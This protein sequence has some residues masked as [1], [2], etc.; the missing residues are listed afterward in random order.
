MEADGGSRGNPGPAGYGAVVLDGDTG[1]L[2]EEIAES[3]G[4]ATNNV[5]EYR[6]LLA[7]LRAAVG[8][9]PACTVEVRMDSK[10]VVEQMSGRWQI[11]HQDMR[12]LAAQ[13]RGVLPADRVTYT[14]IPRAQNTR[15]DALANQAMDA[16]AQ[17][18]SWS[19]R[20]KGAGSATTV[21]MATSSISTS[22]ST[23][24]TSTTSTSLATAATAAAGRTY[25]EAATGP[26]STRAPAGGGDLGAPT[27]LLL[28]RHGRTLLTQERRFSGRGGR[29]AELTSSGRADADRAAELI[30]GLGWPGA[31]LPEIGPATAV[32]SSPLLRTRQ[33]AEAVATRLGLTVTVMDD[34]AEISFGEWDGLTFAEVTERWPD[35]VRRWQGSMT[36]APPGGES[37][38]E[39]VSRVRAVRAATVAAFPGRV[40]VVAT[41]GVPVRAAVHEALDAGPP[42][43]WRTRV[44]PA[45]VTAVR[46]WSDGGIEVSAVNLTVPDRS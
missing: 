11:K 21:S 46:Y 12:A 6:G 37:L 15:A 34:W 43:L 28:L 31:A 32:V 44:D 38:Q 18:R 24:A 29:D 13:A 39:L 30:A 25:A 36:A 3:I 2:L 22:T 41:H 8:I 16:A 40:I 23:S 27:V 33:T 19:R 17:G 7:G 42:A 14:W 45:S 9:D 1:E 20:M 10:L 35:E 26:D 4:R 5:A